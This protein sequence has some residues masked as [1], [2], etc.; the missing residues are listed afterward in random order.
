[1]EYTIVSTLLV[2]LQLMCV[3]I[4]VAYLLTRSK[5][6]LEVLDGHPTVTTQFVL[7]LIFGALSI[8]GTISGIDFM[9]AVV[10]VRD[11][12]PMLAGLLGGPLAQP[13]TS[14]AH[15]AKPPSRSGPVTDSVLMIDSFA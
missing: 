11:L 14:A 6:F 7:I 8:Y 15:K 9:G 5:I 2:L 3:I 1:M 13:A 12:G 4:V 10:N